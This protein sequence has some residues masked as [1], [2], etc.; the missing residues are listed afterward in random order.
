MEIRRFV[1]KNYDDVKAEALSQL[2]VVEEETIIIVN[3]IKGGLFKAAQVEL[4]VV[5]YSDIIEYIKKYLADL[6]NNVG[7][8]LTFESKIRDKQIQIKIYSNDNPMLIG[9]MGK[10]LDSLQ[11]IVRQSIK[12]KFG[13]SPYISID[14]ADYKDKQIS[15]LEKTAKRIAKEVLKTKIEVELDNMNAYE[16]LIVHNAVKDINGIYTESVG[17][18][19]NRHVVIKLKK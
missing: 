17:E 14:I 1:G 5:P 4:T 2:N 19:P 6:F 8:E 15:H 9:K 13:K 3:E 11:T 12:T 10:T 18:E 7:I 16:R